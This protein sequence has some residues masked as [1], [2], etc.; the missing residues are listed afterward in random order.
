M[1]PV[2]DSRAGVWNPPW[3][4]SPLARWN[5]PQKARLSIRTAS[6]SQPDAPSSW[7]SAD[8]EDKTLKVALQI[9]LELQD[10]SSLFLFL[11][12]APRISPLS[13]Q[14]FPIF[15]GSSKCSK[16]SFLRCLKIPQSYLLA[17]Y[18]EQFHC[19][20]LYMIVWWLQM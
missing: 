6:W 3:T 16:L 19:Q 15:L 10:N 4:V 1:I 11:R 14:A 18:K 8:L 13:L 2:L 20:W 5:C 17:H 9:N 7:S 12:S